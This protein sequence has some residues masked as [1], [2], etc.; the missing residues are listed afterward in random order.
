MEE[1]KKAR[2]I[3]NNTG[4]NDWNDEPEYKL[5]KIR[6]YGESNSKKSYIV[7]SYGKKFTC[8]KSNVF[9]NKEDFI[10]K[11]DNIAG[12]RLSEQEKKYLLAQM[13]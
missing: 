6:V 9:F 2:R 5:Q 4:A 11:M 12:F 8:H 13:V 1:Y 3:I 7:D 10:N